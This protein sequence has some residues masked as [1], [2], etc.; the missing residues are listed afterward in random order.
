MKHYLQNSAG[1]S[2]TSVSF[3]ELQLSILLLR[4]YLIAAPSVFRAGVEEAVSVTI[5]NAVKETTVQIQ[6]VVKGE[7]VSRGHGTV[8]GKFL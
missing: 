5:F 7:T 8:L 2:G 4:G 1:G 3:H 6:L